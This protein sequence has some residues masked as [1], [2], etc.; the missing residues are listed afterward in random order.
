MAKRAGTAPSPDPSVAPHT[1][2]ML[3]LREVRGGQA[4]LVPDWT[5]LDPVKKTGLRGP[6]LAPL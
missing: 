5:P 1:L 6:N 3:E 4:A 2:P